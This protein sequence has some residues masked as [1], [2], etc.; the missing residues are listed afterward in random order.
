MKTIELRDFKGIFTNADPDDIPQ[1]F[2]SALVNLRPVNG[3][4]V[5]T[6]GMGL[7]TPNYVL[8]HA[9][10]NLSTFI[11]SHLTL[12]SGYK[13]LAAYITNNTNI[14]TVYGYWASLGWTDICRLSA[15]SIITDTFYQYNGKNPIVIDNDIIRFLPGATALPDGTH[16]AK[17]LWVGW[18]DRDYF[19]GAYSPA[20]RF[21]GYTTDIVAPTLAWT[22]MEYNFQDSEFV[23]GDSYYYK[24]SYVYDGIQESLLSVNPV[25]FT[26]SAANKFPRIVSTTW[27]KTV[28][29]N[30]IT[31]IKVYRSHYDVANG[32]RGTYNHIHTIDFLRPANDLVGSATGC[33]RYDNIVTIPTLITE[34]FATDTQYIFIID[35]GSSYDIDNPGNGTGYFHFHYNSHVVSVEKWNVK[36]EVKK[37]KNGTLTPWLT[38]TSGAYCSHNLITVVSTALP[39]DNYVNGV[40]IANTGSS[41]VYAGIERCADKVIYLKNTIAAQTTPGGVIWKVVSPDKGLYVGNVSG[42]Y[43]YYSFYDTGLAEGAE[44]PLEGEVSVTINAKHARIISDRLWQGNIVLDPADKA[45]AHDDWASYSEEG[46]YDVNPVSNVIRMSDREG[47]AITGLQE[48]FGN[49]VFLKQQA[50]IQ[51]AAKGNNPPYPVQ[52]SAHNIGNIA[53]EGSIEVA[54][55]IYTVWVDGIYRLSP[56][57]LASTDS[58]PTVCLKIT[59]TIEDIYLALTRAQK[60]AILSGYDPLLGEIVW[61]MGSRIMAFNVSTGLWREIESSITP[62]IITTDQNSNLMVYPSTSDPGDK[63]LYTFDPA[64]AKESVAPGMRTKFFTVNDDRPTVIRPLFVTY[65][66]PTTALTLNIYADGATTPSFTTT[67]PASATKTSHRIV[68][69][70]RAYGIEVEITATASTNDVEIYRISISHD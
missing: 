56:N 30:R 42:N 41:Q 63:Y 23:S 9:I 64:A 70:L 53:T 5:K 35:G 36:W 6:F 68:P 27:D 58:T 39:E 65:K 46:Q 57:N 62:A 52:E 31:A 47:G 11:N 8:P 38:G 69:K 40:L 26:P 4:L 22:A 28:Q 37:F 1:E 60:E 55:A 13:Y 25:K 17:G 67:I 29:N 18:I 15:F 50:I 24:F 19:D 45:E 66:S 34:T 21:Y 54:G 16:I 3:K 49:P 33:Y 51:I 43:V 59:D 14:L 32:V 7:L 12:P 20:A 44:H 48:M 10:D 61:T 2:L